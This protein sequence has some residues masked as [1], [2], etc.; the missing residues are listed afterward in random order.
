MRV[1]IVKSYITERINFHKVAFTD[2]CRF[3]L[4]GN[5]NVNSWSKKNPEIVNRRPYKGGSIIIWGT[6]THTGALLLR[7]VEGSLNSE[8]YCDLLT[9]DIIPSLKSEIESFILQQDNVPCHNS[10][11]TISTIKAAGIEILNW[12]PHSP[13][14]SPIEKIWSILKSKVYEH[15]NFQDNTSLWNK[16]QNEAPKIKINDPDLFRKL[17]TRFYESMCDILCSGGELIK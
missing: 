12:P 1:Q 7:K 10:K 11:Y 16:I 17:Y 8:K 15:G 13:D 6:M 5:D 3:T 4:D 2:E 9:K 14:L